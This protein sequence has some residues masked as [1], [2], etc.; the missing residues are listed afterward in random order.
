MRIPWRRR[1]THL[2]FWLILGFVLL[3][4]LPRI[5]VHPD[6]PAATETSPVV[7]NEFQ[8]AAAAEAPLLDERG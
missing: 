5:F 1:R 3:L 8:A 6:T 2:V 4:A 7:I